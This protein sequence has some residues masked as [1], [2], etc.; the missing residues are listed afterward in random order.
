MADVKTITFDLAGQ[1]IDI[2]KVAPRVYRYQDT[3]HIVFTGADMLRTIEVLNVGASDTWLFVLDA[4]AAPAGTTT[5]ALCNPV[6]PAIKLPALATS[7]VFRGIYRP[8]MQGLVLLP[9]STYLTYTAAVIQIQAVV[10]YGR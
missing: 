9:S 1:V 4:A 3:S 6:C 2:R 7:P 10:E 8:M 5:W